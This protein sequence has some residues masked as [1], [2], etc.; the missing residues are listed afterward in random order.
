[1]SF[2]SAFLSQLFHFT[3]KL[4]EARWGRSLLGRRTTELKE[5]G[6]VFALVVEVADSESVILKVIARI[7][8]G[9][10]RELG[11]CV[12]RVD[13]VIDQ[14][15]IFHVLDCHSE[16]EQTHRLREVDLHHL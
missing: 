11:H 7:V 1:M 12:G 14:T 4:D 5:D 3:I 2:Q 10:I 15:T 9:M 16:R 13:L 8:N 6:Q